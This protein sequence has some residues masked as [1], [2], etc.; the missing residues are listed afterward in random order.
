M[1]ECVFTQWRLSG[2]WVCSLSGGCQ[3]SECVHSV[4]VVR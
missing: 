3:V 2:E 4:E 1:S